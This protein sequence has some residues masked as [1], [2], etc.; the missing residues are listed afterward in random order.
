MRGRGR[1]QQG[2]ARSRAC[3]PSRAEWLLPAPQGPA[4]QSQEVGDQGQRP[5]V[6]GGPDWCCWEVHML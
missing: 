3:K 6:A 4:H 1:L 2:L 5:R